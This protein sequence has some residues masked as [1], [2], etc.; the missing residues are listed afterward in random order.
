MIEAI[1]EIKNE[2]ET[3]IENIATQSIEH[4]HANEVVLTMGKSQT[5]EAFLK[6][7]LS[8]FFYFKTIKLQKM[9]QLY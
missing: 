9:I 3:S 4:I 8:V 6:V 1:S 5:V 2:I 7:I